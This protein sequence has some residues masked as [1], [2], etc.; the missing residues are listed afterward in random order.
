MFKNEYSANR[1]HEFAAIPD[2]VVRGSYDDIGERLTT[3]NNNQSTFKSAIVREVIFDPALLDDTR[4]AE[5]VEKYSIAE[6]AYI[7]SL[8]RHTVLAQ[9]TTSENSLTTTPMFFFPFFPPHMI[10]PIKAGEKVWT[11]C[12][13]GKVIDY[14]Y[15]ICRISEPRNVDDLNF[16]HSDRKFDFATKK[17]EAPTFA[18]GPRV[19]EKIKGEKV[20][21]VDPSKLSLVSGKNQPSPEKEFENILKDSDAGVLTDYEAVPRF[22][23]RPGDF[24]LQGSNNTLISLGTDR[25]ADPCEVET[26]TSAKNRKGKRAKGKPKSDVSGK[27]GTIDIVAGRGQSDKT[28]QKEI[29]NTLGKF[30][31]DKQIDAPK[32]GNPDFDSDLS[33]IYVSMNTGVDENFKIK[34]QDSQNKSKRITSTNPDSAIVVKSNQLRL[35]AR[36]E[37]RMM[38]QVKPDDDPSKC[39]TIILRSSG[40]IVLLPAKDGV[41]RLGAEDAD[42]AILCANTAGPV[43]GGTVSGTPIVLEA[44][45]P[46]GATLG[47]GLVG[48]I[49]ASKVVVK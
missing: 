25:V 42:K 32:E 10:L 3:L 38:V 29:K 30:E 23:A 47:D 19:E 39:A 41:V 18:N 17:G 48:G 37:I 28:K 13:S 7:K 46:K 40:D 26:N 31:T 27:A 11:F 20:V 4:I 21:T 22:T 43:T 15:W 24:I 16:T 36:N 14:G 2:S 44:N 35:I 33:R 1:A 12:E 49:F 5:L 34:F 6:T 9:Y 8:P 45:L